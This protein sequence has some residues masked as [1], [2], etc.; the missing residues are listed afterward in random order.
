[1][2]LVIPHLDCNGNF[3]SPLFVAPTLFITLDVDIGATIGLDGSAGTTGAFGTVVATGATGSALLSKA[4]HTF[5]VLP[6]SPQK[7]FL[8]KTKTDGTCL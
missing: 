8:R 3:A 6:S 4:Q 2:T 1:V 7:D 5:V